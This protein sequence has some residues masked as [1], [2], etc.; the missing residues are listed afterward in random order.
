MM[1][2]RNGFTIYELVLGVLIL[3]LMSVMLFNLTIKINELYNKTT[4]DTKM[5]NIKYNITK[6]LQE[7]MLSYKLTSVN[8]CG[9]S[10]IEMLYDEAL[11]KRLK[12]D[13]TNKTI[14]YGDYVKKIPSGVT[15]NPNVVLTNTY[16]EDV[17]NGSYNAITK[18]TMEIISSLST[19]DFSISAINQHN[20]YSAEMFLEI[21]PVDMMTGIGDVGVLSYGVYSN[22]AY[23]YHCLNSS[24]AVVLCESQMLNTIGNYQVVYSASLNDKTITKIRNLEVGNQI[25]TVNPLVVNINVND[26]YYLLTGV[27]TN[28]GSINTSC[29]KDNVSV[30]CG[31]ISATWGTYLVTYIPTTA[32]ASIVRTIN[33]IPSQITVNPTTVE[34]IKGSAIDF[35]SGVSINYGTYSY[36]CKR[37]STTVSCSTIKDSVDTYTVTYTPILPG[38]EVT[39]TI[40]VKDISIWNIAYTGTVHTFTAPYAGTY[41]F[42]MWGAAGGACDGAGGKGAYTKGNLNMTAGQT[43]YISVGQK[44]ADCTGG[45]AK[46]A[47]SVGGGGQGGGGFNSSSTTGA[48]GGGA[49]DVRTTSGAW[50]NGINLGNRIMVAAG[51]GGGSQNGAGGAGGALAANGTTIASGAG[52][53]AANQTGTMGHAIGQH[54][55][56]GTN[57]SNGDFGNGGG[58]GGH[59]GGS[60]YQGTGVNTGGPGGGG[61]SYISGYTGASTILSPWDANPK[62]G[63]VDGTTYRACS[64]HPSGLI[65]LNSG[66]QM[67]AG[68]ASMPNPTSSGTMTGNAGNGYARITYNITPIAPETPN[69]TLPPVKSQNT[70][71]FVRNCINGFLEQTNEGPKVRTEN[72]WTELEAYVGS[73]NIALG[74]P[75]SGNVNAPHWVTDGVKTAFQ[76]TYSLAT[77]NQ[78]VVVDLLY[79]Y[80]LDSIKLWHIFG[81]GRLYYDNVISVAGY[82]N[83]GIT[84][85]RNV[86]SGSYYEAPAGH[87]VTSS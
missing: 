62:P 82:P 64:Y 45:T 87:T 15:V 19:K 34:T 56:N 11:I 86:Y 83:N 42:E 4:F 76:G 55:R 33:V 27:N 81:D 35:A 59:W 7:D 68:T 40:I 20:R 48:S 73:T 12:I 57:H 44:G 39:R 46:T 72:H 80:N 85:W 43:L 75:V 28:I 36:T 22:V 24:G 53:P 6:L 50:N 16:I 65:F 5:L 69:Q 1:K 74:K 63:C 61:S 29:K 70:V 10:C 67:T 31:T 18:L 84:T 25:I 52:I 2:R 9:N 58:G 51:G 23:V 66:I 17:E 30:D 54:G 41:T 37:G 38:P 14:S 8:Q 78:C 13:E 49:T 60:S 3:I 79:I 21:D 26:P 47:A 71:R 77:G 32:G